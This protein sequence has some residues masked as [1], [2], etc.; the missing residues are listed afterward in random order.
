MSTELLI[1]VAGPVL[2][3]LAAV[4]A[5]LLI[6]TRRRV[7]GTRDPR[8]TEAVPVNPMTSA[9]ARGVGLAY[10]AAA[11]GVGLLLLL[12]LIGSR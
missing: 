9:Q 7:Q 6:K 12:A 1:V 4:G 2:M 10:L 5:V 8:H 3:A 11:A